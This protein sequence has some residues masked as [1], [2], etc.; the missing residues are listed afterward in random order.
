ML[1]HIVVALTLTMIISS[2][3][4]ESLTLQVKYVQPSTACTNEPCTFD[5]F[6]R[7]PEQYFCS[8]TTFIFLPGDHQL[9][10]NISLYGIQ[11]VTFQGKAEGTVTIRL[12]P[13]VGLSFDN[14]DG[15]EI[16]SLTFLLSNK[17]E[18]GL[19][20]S[21]TNGIILHNIMISTGNRHSSGCSAIL[22][23]ASSININDSSFMG[24]NGQN[25]AALLALNSSMI[26]FTGSNNF[27]NNSANL[28]GAIHSVNSTIQFTETASFINNSAISNE[29]DTQCYISSTSGIGGAIFAKASNLT[30]NSCS[31][32]FFAMDNSAMCMGGAI[33][34]VNNSIVKIGGSS[35]FNEL[36]PI[37]V[38]FKGNYV[39]SDITEALEFTSEFVESGGG[40]AIFTYGCNVNITNV[41]L[42]DNISPGS[43]G[44]A[45]FIQSN[46]TLYNINALNNRVNNYNYFGGAI[47]IYSCK[48][49]HIHGDN[50]FIN[51]SAMSYGG[52]MDVEAVQYLNMGGRNYFEG[53]NAESGGA[54]DIY[55][56]TMVFICGDNNVFQ[57]NS[58]TNGGTAYVYNATVH[59]C[60]NNTFAKSIADNQGGAIYTIA[61]TIIFNGTNMILFSNNTATFDGGAITNIDSQMKLY[62][63]I[64][65]ENNSANKGNGGAMALYGASKFIL[66]PLTTV[67]F[68][69]NYANSD[70][71]AMYFE[72][73][74]TARLNC[75][76]ASAECFIVLNTTYDLFLNNVSI[77]LKFMNN[78]AD[79]YG[80]VLY[81]G[82]LGRC[83]VLFKNDTTN[84]T[85]KDSMEMQDDSYEIVT[86]I[87]TIIGE[88]ENSSI[89]LPPEKLC[90]CD[91]TLYYRCTSDFIDTLYI[92]KEV[93]PG[94]IFGISM[95]AQ[96][97]RNFNVPGIMVLSD[98]IRES[99]PLSQETNKTTSISCQAF[100]YR[101][102]VESTNVTPSYNFYISGLC[103]FYKG[104]I[105]LDIGIL[106]CPI[107]FKFSNSERKCICTD[108]LKQFTEECSVDNQSVNR[109]R[110]DFWIKLTA[111]YF[112]IFEGSCPLDYCI[113]STEVVTIKHNESDVQCYE[114]RTG[115]ICGSCKEDE[116]YSLV[117]GS[118]QCQQNCTHIFLL[119]TIPFG[120]LGILLV[121]L[122]FLLHLTVSAGTI[123]GMIFYANIVQA[124]HQI[125]LPKVT[126][127]FNFF[128]V[129]ISWL[130]LDF[131]IQSCFF[132][133]MNIFIYSWLQFLF[134]L[135]LWILVFMIIISARYSRRV[136]KMLGQNPVA[137]LATVLLISYSKML[138][139]IIAPLSPAMLKN[140]TQSETNITPY[141]WLY[142][143]DRE[144]LGEPGH[145]SLVA[146]SILILVLLFFPYTMFI[147]CSHWLQIK[148]HWCILSWINKLKP[149]MDA[150]YAP[151]KKSKRHW[152]GLLLLVRCGLFLNIAFNDRGINLT[153]ISTVVAGLLVI[154]GQ[155][156][157]KWYNDFLESSFLFNLCILSI[158][159]SYVQSEKSFG[160][161]EVTRL[162]NI[163][164]SVSVG[165]AFV[166][167][168][169]IIVFHIYQQ[170]RKLN[171]H[172]PQSMRKR[173]S[174]KKEHND[175]AFSEQSL[176]I[177]TNASTT[178]VNLRELL[179]DDEN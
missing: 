137:V 2:E 172:V 24:I 40:G 58:A 106:P 108:V 122:V 4:V 47:R 79:N 7:N 45:Y 72:D 28:G 68:L 70:G 82:Q 35:C 83:N 97:Q 56:V 166:Y 133:G 125:F 60:G 15:I 111:N 155:S 135:Y 74:L 152:L 126:S 19:M 113:N 39:I 37:S 87:S 9:S 145:R 168:I 10:N 12:G 167:F 55:S 31:G 53:N 102:L 66:N 75:Y 121:V 123:N 164:S 109:L 169:G 49:V 65:F 41:S 36:Y 153:V 132:K 178:S 104:N 100:T 21:N 64:Q 80:A 142:N 11:N 96:D 71:G 94:Q 151:F 77:L 120:A 115:I 91:N 160:P 26:T 157:E 138:E 42:T 17:F 98:P 165:I 118:L 43:G 107:G 46:V 161:D 99:Y 18:Y 13:Q 81:G 38:T 176:E 116:G 148:S 16:K 67:D 134:P 62:G 154:K 136:A 20:F 159:S 177:I 105:R 163:L 22:S 78:V 88:Q 30:I 3:P 1:V 52:A 174:L 54:F 85:C 124:N 23:Q 144:Y 112:L 32:Q 140:V 103:G 84:D 8:N 129:F 34:A 33:A 114:G 147:L 63:K 44:A 95:V 128:T 139:A 86:N 29:N 146:V 61:A 89:A 150:Y 119:L 76:V 117:L 127:K 179:L 50:Y 162:Q 5:Q 92:Y 143:G 175:K 171:L 110:N 130:N 156:Y 90:L 59:F 6:A 25:G 51:N 57:G 131:G 158:A 141:V 173:Y 101:L 27:S 149:L 73:S 14:C 48:Q 69:E 93:S 170:M